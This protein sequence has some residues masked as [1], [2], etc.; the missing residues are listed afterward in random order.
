MAASLNTTPELV[1]PES[2]GH[3]FSCPRS[4]IYAIEVAPESGQPDCHRDGKAPPVTPQRT[5]RA[6]SSERKIPVDEIPAPG[7]ATSTRRLRHRDSVRRMGVRELE[8]TT[9]GEIA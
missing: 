3:E 8:R 6:L 5:P 4:P 2:K 7:S 9:E 1:S